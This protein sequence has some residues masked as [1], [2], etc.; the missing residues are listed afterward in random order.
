MSQLLSKLS[1]L[2]FQDKLLGV[3]VIRCCHLKQLVLLKGAVV[4]MKS[5]VVFTTLRLSPLT[6]VYFSLL[7]VYFFTLQSLKTTAFVV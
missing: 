5:A 2:T 4:L 7:L 1:Q 6:L 3:G